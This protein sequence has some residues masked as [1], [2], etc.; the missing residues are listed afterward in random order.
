MPT[1]A[2]SRMRSDPVLLKTLVPLASIADSLRA[3]DGQLHAKAPT[4]PPRTPSLVLPNASG[5]PPTY[6]ELV[7]RV[8]SAWG[9]PSGHSCP[10]PETLWWEAQEEEEEEERCF[11]RPQAEVSFCPPDNPSGLLGL[12]NRPLEPKV[13][14]TLRG[15]LLEHHP[16]STA[17]HLLLA[18]CQAAGLLGVTK[19]QQDAMGV[20]SGLEL[21]TLPHGHRLRSEL[22]ERHE[23]LVLAGALAVLGCTGPLE[24]RAAALRGLVE[25]AL[26]LRPGAAG[27]LPGLAA[28]MGA[29]LMPQVSR[30]ERTWRQL[31]RSHTEAALAFE[32]ELKPLM[33][34][35]DEGAGPCNPGEVALPHVAP[36]VRLLEGEELPGPLDESCEQLL[37]TLQGARLMARDAPKFR[38]AAAGRLRGFRPNRELR[39]ALT[40]GFVRRLLWGSRGEGSSRA[41]RVEKF[42]RVLN[43]LS[44]R[45]EPDS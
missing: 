36:A 6:C 40:T 45:L 17:L 25:L 39:E 15:L 24:E 43:V 13:L 4:K 5:H 14:R 30:L 9:T 22:L 34:A 18:D 31:R 16:G 3:S 26:A 21:L 33:R 38:E 8:P 1:I 23:A 44:Q 29:L 2:L 10:E 11:V 35:L 27:D 37:R 7:P 28:V 41:A 32:Q 12:Q 42:Q 20:A 19:V